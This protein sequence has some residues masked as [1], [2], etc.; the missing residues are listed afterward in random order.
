MALQDQI[1]GIQRQYHV[2]AQQA[3]GLSKPRTPKSRQELVSALVAL[4]AQSEAMFRNKEVL[5]DNVWRLQGEHDQAIKRYR[6]LFQD[7]GNS[8]A[9]KEARTSA[10]NLLAEWRTAREA[11]GALEDRR[12]ALGR[13]IDQIKAQLDALSKK[14]NSKPRGKK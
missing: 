14:Q 10:D 8:P 5:R 12:T 1:D 3:G 6:E 9:V 4:E 11:L 2:L 13:E 7:S